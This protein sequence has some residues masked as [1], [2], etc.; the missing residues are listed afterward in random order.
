MSAA[1][2]AK[3]G[4]RRINLY[5][6]TKIVIIGRP[7]TGKST[8]FN[9]IIGQHKAVTS[10]I[11]GTTRDA[12]CGN[13]SW[14]GKI[15]TLFDTGGFEYKVAQEDVINKSVQ[16]QIKFA[17]KKA[18]IILFIV[19]S[20][21]GITSP[22]INFSKQLKKIKKPIIL[23]ANKAD[24]DNLREKATEMVRLG[25]GQPEI[26]SAITGIGT[27]D[28]LDKISSLI[29]KTDKNF[30][31]Q[32]FYQENQENIK[33]IKVGLFGKPNVGKSSIINAL[34]G[35]KKVIVSEIPGTTRDT[36]ENTI[37]YKDKKITLI[38]SAG[39]KRKKEANFGIE[40]F[41]IRH[42]LENIRNCD[43]VL[44][45][46]SCD[47]FLSRQ[48]KR[49]SQRI[50]ESNASI[51]IIVNKLDLIKQKQ[52]DL[53]TFAKSL[54]YHFNFLYFAP[55]VFTS[56]KTDQNI[57]EI[58]DLIINANLER[59]KIIDQEELTKFLLELLKD[60]P[61]HRNKKSKKRPKLVR[62]IQFRNNPPKFNL[63]LEGPET[64]APQYLR[65]LERKLHEQY[66]FEGAPLHISVAHENK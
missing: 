24:N 40:K 51:I 58:F 36:I 47:D 55:I 21:A 29:K 19:D 2:E 32:S 8:L 27:G 49:I 38:D 17:L 10:P 65:F 13:S 34:I 62:L 42:S 28:L 20:K 39:I 54:R 18:D 57:R 45:V 6:E 15:F 9:K 41:S 12:V 60:Y 1:A 63:Y 35:E 44:F 59:Q 11:A 48:D 25:L 53:D 16:E 56:A 14:K 46:L 31:M 30:G 64:I 5:M 26:I 4:R 22:D 52:N 66:G 43:I 50:L 37:E 3:A 23:V 61:P 7:N 33:T